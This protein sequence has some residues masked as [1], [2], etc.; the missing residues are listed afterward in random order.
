M[1]SGTL[2]ARCELTAGIFPY[3][4][5]LASRGHGMKKRAGHESAMAAGAAKRA[6]LGVGEIRE[7]FVTPGSDQ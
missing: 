6:A 5:P 3:S 7:R 1:R 4:R 2:V